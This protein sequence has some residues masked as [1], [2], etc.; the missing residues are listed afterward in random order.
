MGKHLV[1]INQFC[2]AFR[3]LLYNWH[4]TWLYW[5]KSIH[6]SWSDMEG[7]LVRILYRLNLKYKQNRATLN[8]GRFWTDFGNSRWN[9]KEYLRTK[10]W[11]Q[12][13][14]MSHQTSQLKIQAILL[15]FN[16]IQ[17]STLI[18]L[19]QNTEHDSWLITSTFK[20]DKYYHTIQSWF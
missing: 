18:I 17:I 5:L 20:I 13:W 2:T 15:Y 7:Y 1:T 3:I 8:C 6:S 11:L 9:Y 19:K 16:T 12:D 10:L 4:I 14:N